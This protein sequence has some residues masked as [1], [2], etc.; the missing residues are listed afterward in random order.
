[1]FPKGCQFTMP[2][3]L[4]G[5]PWKVLAIICIHISH[6]HLQKIRYIL[7]H[8]IHMLFGFHPKLHFSGLWDLPALHVSLG[9]KEPRSYGMLSS[10]KN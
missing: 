7:F 4:I 5:T 3:V 1:M 2:Y 8:I 10:I 9:I 6:I